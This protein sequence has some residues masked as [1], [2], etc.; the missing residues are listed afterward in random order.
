MSIATAAADRRTVLEVLSVLPLLGAEPHLRKI[1]AR[2]TALAQGALAVLAEFWAHRDGHDVRLGRI[3]GVSDPS[4]ATVE[5]ALDAGRR[6]VL[7]PMA[8][9]LGRYADEVLEERGDIDVWHVLLRDSDGAI[10]TIGDDRSVIQA[11]RVG[12]NPQ[13]VSGVI[14]SILDNGPL[15]V[16]LDLKR[17]VS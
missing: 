13:A 1:A 17:V 16:E 10:V 15:M 6:L 8:E 2:E 14:R 7:H 12:L 3:R 9:A 5:V 11:S 4:H